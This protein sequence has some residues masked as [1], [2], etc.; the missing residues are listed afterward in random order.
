M[1]I[2]ASKERF[3]AAKKESVHAARSEESFRQIIAYWIPE[4]VTNSV[5]FSLP[6]FV[7]AYLIACLKSTTTYGTFSIATTLFHFVTKFAESFAVGSTTLVGQNNGAEKYEKCGESL[8]SSFWSSIFLGSSMFT[9][10]YFNAAAIYRWHN[11][12]E[13]M[14]TLGAPFLQLRAVGLLLVFVFM[15]FLGFLRGVKNTKVPMYINLVGIGTFF[16][17]DYAL[18]LG[19]FGFPAL[20]LTGSAISTILQ[21]LVMN[22]LAIFYILREPEYKKY[23]SQ[24]FLRLFDLR[25]AIKLF[26]LSLPII[27]DKSSLAF[28]YVWLTASIAS[29]GSMAIASY[30]T[31]KELERFALLPAVAFA[32][33]ITFLVS[34]RVGA[35]DFDGA[36]SI[37]K[38]VLVLTALTV[39]FTLVVL[40]SFPHFFIGLFDK[41]VNASYTVFAAPLLQILS[42]LVVF[43]FMQLILAG[44]LRGAGDVQSVM[45]VRSAS[46]AIFAG[47]T[48][49]IKWMKV[50]DPFYSFLFNYGSFYVTTAFMGIFFLLRI[51]NRKWES[52][53]HQNIVGRMWHSI[54]SSIRYIVR[55]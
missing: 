52:K 35:Q 46:L 47:L 7:D 42:M 38:K 53:I 41:D 37:M 27:I 49:F 3:I 39:C 44:A 23:F 33:V 10:V 18:I 8:G 16:F 15:A 4:L 9:I 36:K 19:R 2:Q 51:K 13:E 32:Q 22:S 14:I 20:G 54:V 34:N 45:I 31:I 5:I 25:Q 1:Q 48:Y 43:D 11:I 50:T 6:N 28:M 12:P 17:F 26:T 29:H 40:C 30:N 24:T 55:F 21:Y